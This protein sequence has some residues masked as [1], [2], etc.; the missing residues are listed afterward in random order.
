MVKTLTE[1][2]AN[3]TPEEQAAIEAEA[4]ELIAEEMYL[5]E[6]KKAYHLTQTEISNN[7]GITQE[8]LSNLEEKTDLILSTLATYLQDLGVNLKLVAEFPEQKT[9]V[10]KGLME[11][12]KD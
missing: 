4:K 1:I 5:R 6:L 12:S 9:I 2:M 11:L 8:T 3:F 10:I 7:L